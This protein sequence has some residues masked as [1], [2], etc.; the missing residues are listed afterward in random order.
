M[1][2]HKIISMKNNRI[3][4]LLAFLKDD[5]EDSFVI[6]ALAKEYEKV[7][8]K[9]KAIDTFVKLKELDPNYVGL[10]Y[11][12]GALHEELGD[13][14]KAIKTY[15]EGIAI[16]KKLADFHALSELHNAKTNLEVS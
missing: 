7:G 9:K 8:T 14:E 12:L 5:P 13:K 15:E 4:T 10:Y 2:I 6:F 1:T 16:A 3:D 11:H